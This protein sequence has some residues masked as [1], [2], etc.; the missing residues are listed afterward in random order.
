MQRII[1]IEN[2]ITR[3]PMWRMAEPVN[4]DLLDKEHL[5]IVGPNGGGNLLTISLPVPSR[6]PAT[7]SNTSRSKTTTA[8]ITTVPISCSSGGT[9]WK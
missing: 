3:H 7:T 5:A 9:P 2:G 1:H 8:G 6:W 4:F